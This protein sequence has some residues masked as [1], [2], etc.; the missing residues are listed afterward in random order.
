MHEISLIQSI[1]QAALDEAKQAGCNQIKGIHAKVRESIHPMKPDHLQE[2]L[3][4]MAK[5]TIAEGA[6]MKIEV[7]PPTLRC[8]E[9]GF[10]FLP[11]GNT[12]FCPQCKGGK[13]EEI[14]AEEVSLENI[15]MG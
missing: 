1:L 14:D 5:D 10:T 4:L 6:E 9:C 3:E 8:K 11:Q 13:L 15:V 7:V 2:L 12:L